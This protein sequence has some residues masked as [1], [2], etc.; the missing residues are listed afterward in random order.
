MKIW[1]KSMTEELVPRIQTLIMELPY[2]NPGY[3]CVIWEQWVEASWLPM[4]DCE[5]FKLFV[6]TAV[7]LLL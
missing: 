2:F 6:Y 3:L 5:V 1:L 4:T 7:V